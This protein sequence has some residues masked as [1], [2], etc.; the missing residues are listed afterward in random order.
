MYVVAVTFTI[1]PK[2]ITQFLP[3]IK[4]QAEDSLSKE[5]NCTQFDISVAE[6]HENVVF[7]YEIYTSKEDFDHHL[8][9]AHFQSFNELVSPWVKAKQ[10]E[11]FIRQ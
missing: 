1:D 8:T 7:L 4:K 6:E 9:T 3:V 5:P 10:V 11:T 2:Y